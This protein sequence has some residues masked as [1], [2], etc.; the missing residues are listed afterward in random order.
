MVLLYHTPVKDGALPSGHETDFSAILQAMST[1]AA[2]NDRRALDMDSGSSASLLH[3]SHKE[4]PKGSKARKLASIQF[5]TASLDK[6][7]RDETSR[8]GRTSLLGAGRRASG[9]RSRVR[10]VRQYIGWLTAAH[11]ECNPT[12]REHVTD[13]LHVS[14]V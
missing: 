10:E 2:H 4:E 8:P 12:Q 14:V 1:A 13:V 9:L 5:V 11:T 7:R 6:P 3:R